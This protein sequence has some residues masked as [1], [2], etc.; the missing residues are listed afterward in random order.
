M[1]SACNACVRAIHL[2]TVNIQNFAFRVN[3]TIFTEI[4]VRRDYPLEISQ[5]GHYFLCEDIIET[6][7][8]VLHLCELER[9]Q[10]KTRKTQPPSKL[11]DHQA[12]YVVWDYQEEEDRVI[13]AF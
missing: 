7:F 10:K 2:R 11:Q 12:N 13:V 3:S 5:R 1:H 8:A 4:R 6:S 9:E